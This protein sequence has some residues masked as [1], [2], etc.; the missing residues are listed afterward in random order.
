MTVQATAM[1]EQSATMDVESADL[2]GTTTIKQDGDGSG[3]GT[4]PSGGSGSGMTPKRSI[5]RKLSISEQ[6][7]AG[8]TGR[9]RAPGF[10][11]WLEYPF[12]VKNVQTHQYLEE[13]TGHAMDVAARGPINQCGSFVG[14]A[15]IRLAAMEAGGIN[16]K[17]YGIKASSVLT[18]GSIIVGVT[19]G[20][21]MPFV[22]AI[23]DHTD[24]RKAMGAVSAVVIVIAV[25][26][27]LMLSPD[28]WLAVFILEIIGGYF[29]IMHQVCTMAYLPDLTHDH[30]EMGD[31]T[32][33]LMM[34]QYFVQATFT[35]IVIAVSFGTNMSN[36]N[37]ARLA[38]GISTVIGFVFFGYSWMF[39]FRKRPKLRELPPGN[40]LFTSGFKQLLITTKLV[41]R[42]YKAL[43]WF[44]IALLFSP[45]AGAG[46]VLAIA[47]TFLTLFVQMDVK[48]IAIVS[49]TMLFCNIPGAYISKRMCVKINPLNSF[50]CA[51]IMFAG[52]NGLIAGTVSGSTQ[53]DKNLVYF[54]GALVGVAFGWMFPSQRTLAVALI[55]KGQETEIMGLISFFGQVVGWLPVFVFT[56]MNE[57]D[58]SM[59]W[60]LASVSFFLMVSCFFTLFCGKF[61]DAVALVAHTSDDY[62]NAY[63]RKSGLDNGGSFVDNFVDDVPQSEEDKKQRATEGTEVTA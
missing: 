54:Y 60:G 26:F 45:E 49:L 22:G 46:V 52:V 34:N 53:K 39:L 19:A 12:R 29:L 6:A 30:T 27:Q 47:V 11:K 5:E 61:E 4:S 7:T 21:T 40:N 41:F 15:M 9:C 50:R 48:E 14:S 57:N 38:A 36:L 55:P 17:V 43:K 32:A 1:Q 58:I 44:M 37:T 42:E 62:L 51:E 13:A 23:V 2:N 63:S 59:R 25:G 18:V 24:H 3:S 35:S 33:R 28:T 16:N 10:L 20:V 31:Y 8:S 56:A